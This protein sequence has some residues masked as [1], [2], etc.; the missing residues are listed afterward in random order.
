MERALTIRDE[1]LLD[2]AAF[3]PENPHMHKLAVGVLAFLPLLMPVSAQ[4]G[5]TGL[6][7]VWKGEI[8][9]PERAVEI[10]L[11]FVADGQGGWRGSVDTP[12]Q[13]SFGLP[14][15]TVE[16]D[17]KRL[18][19]H[20]QVADATLEATLA[21]SGTELVGLWTQRGNEIPVHCERQPFPPALPTELARQIAGTWEGVLSVGPVEL[22]LVLVVKRSSGEFLEGHMVSPD[23]SPAEY[24]IGRVDFAGERSVLVH[25]GAVGT[26]FAVTLSADG[27]SL[28]GKFKQAGREFDIVLA[29]VAEVSKLSRPQEPRGPF[30]YEIEEVLYENP[31]A[32][33]TL[34]GT[35]T[36]P[37]GQGP[38]P[39]AI[40]ITGSG[41]QDRNEEIFEHKPFWVIADHLTRA[42]IAVLRVD[43]RGMGGSSK[44]EASGGATS[45][46]FA[47][48]VGAGM[49]F[50]QR[51]ERIAPDKIGLI[52]HSE[53]GVIAPL[54]ARERNDVAF[55]VLLAGTGVR[56]DKLLVMQNA[57]IMR[58]SD[59]D[60]ETI[61]AAC[62]AQERLFAIVLDSALSPQELE[63]RLTRVIQVEE[64]FQ[65]ASAE[66]Q[67]QGLKTALAQLT[68]PWMVTFIRH[69]PAAVLR[70][71]R[72]PVL[73]LN[74]ELDLQVP[75]KANL[76]GIAMAL[77]AAENPDFTTRAFPG[78]N[79]LYQHC[80]T[81][82]IAEY[83]KIEETFSVEVLEVM[84]AWIGER[85]ISR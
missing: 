72:C 18:V 24:A 43:D 45:F 58:A 60:E 5:V 2:K 77:E 10:V 63:T 65:K 53:G 84:R 57:A 54:V 39:A 78:L 59:I 73:A 44:G 28:E 23:Q 30:P 48:D 20:S 35:L 83:G 11:H 12:A 76:D 38:F 69:D 22:R 7:G 52:G 49:D 47:G 1:F 14:W 61:S 21:E 31:A 40:L 85:V 79:H 42:G 17:G 51:H 16:W 26:T 27:A 67:A 71:V 70:K 19:V 34:A 4:E 74:G 8:A 3:R 32:G 25:V 55:A 82:L 68:N 13:L 15:D 6:A 62:S 66:D 81:G 36:L 64:E 80:E 56:G 46:D 9:T 75:F 37:E 50:L 33:V 41:G 29:R